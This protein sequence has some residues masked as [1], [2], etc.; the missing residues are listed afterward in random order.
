MTFHEFSQR[1]THLTGRLYTVL[2][3]GSLGHCGKGTIAFF[4]VRLDGPSGIYLGRDVQ[5]YSRAWLIAV[6]TWLGQK[7]GGRLEVGDGSVIGH[8]AQISAARSIK[9]GKRVGVASGSVIVDHLHD[10][11]YPDVAILDAPLS[12]PKPIVIGDNSFIGVNA[13]ITPGVTVGEHAFVGANAVVVR[14]VPPYTVVSGNPARVI[15]TITS[16]SEVATQVGN[17]RARNA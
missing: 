8:G 7:Y 9:I 10:Y 13:V 11:R 17:Q 2:L 6:D 5:L 12:T 14:D 3:R 1:F 15:R 16:E 4:P